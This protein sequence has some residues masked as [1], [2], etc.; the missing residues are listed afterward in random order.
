VP[1]ISGSD[2]AWAGP[3]LPPGVV[4]IPAVGDDVTVSFEHGDTDFPVWESGA[5]AEGGDRATKGYIG[6][7]RGVVVDSADPMTQN[8]L[9]I[10]VPEVADAESA[11]A[12]PGVALGPDDA[13]PAVGTEVWVEFEQGDVAYPI[14]V[15][16]V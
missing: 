5:P 6:K 16:L 12:T 15:G 9:R 7:Y 13:L 1:E 4:Q 2:S 10:S 3:S 11:W 8:R 14:W